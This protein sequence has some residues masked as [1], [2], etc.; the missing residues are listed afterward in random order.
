MPGPARQRTPEAVQKALKTGQI[1]TADIDNRI[2]ATLKLLRQTGK[3]DDRKDTP[4][5]QAIDL[6]E[7]RALIRKAGSEGIV[8][9]KNDNNILPIKVA[10][11]RKI[12]LLGPLATY[13][14]AHGGGSAS[15]NCHYKV[16][17]YDAFTERLGKQVEITHSKGRYDILPML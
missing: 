15:L 14:A 6:P 9:L 4:K 3:F 7:H 8:L 17:P 16:S 11:T 13:S 2:L 5:E 10:N 12:A 1:S